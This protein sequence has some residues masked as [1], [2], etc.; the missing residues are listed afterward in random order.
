MAY[1]QML[2]SNDHIVHRLPASSDSGGSVTPAYAAPP[3]LAKL[4]VDGLAWVC[5]V[6]KD[7][8][9]TLAVDVGF[10]LDA[11]ERV[12]IE[13]AGL[14]PRH[15]FVQTRTGDR[16]ELCLLIDAPMPEVPVGHRPRPP[17]FDIV[18]P[19]RLRIG[20]RLF[21]VTLRDLSEQGAEIDTSTVIH[22]PASRSTIEF[23]PDTIALLNT[24]GLEKPRLG[25][26][27]WSAA[28]RIGFRFQD[29]L[30][31][32]ELDALVRAAAGRTDRD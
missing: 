6:A 12:M 25:E 23:T 10:R 5:R 7:E 18:Q 11:G 13:R 9:A 3:T 29:R 15:A 24:A 32:R 20:H 30:S 17:R 4:I 16:A 28:N 27:R 1:A 26:I 22:D 19:G 2:L 14:P 21:R 8:G 31:F